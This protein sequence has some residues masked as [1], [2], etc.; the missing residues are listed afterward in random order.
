MVLHSFSWLPIPTV[1][2]MFTDVIIETSSPMHFALS[3]LI[4]VPHE[5]SQGPHFLHGHSTS[6]ACY[7]RGRLNWLDFLA[8]RLRYGAE[9]THVESGLNVPSELSAL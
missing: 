8:A 6:G 4:Y 3:D 2:E 5:P 7:V 1:L 9:W